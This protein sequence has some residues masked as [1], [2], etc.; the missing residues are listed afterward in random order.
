MYTIGKLVKK[1]NISRSTLLY[2]DKIGL[3][4]PNGRSQSN[5]RLY[6]E[7]DV[8]RLSE[9]MSHREAGIPLSDMNRL[10]EIEKNDVS[11]T[12]SKRLKVIQDEI[13]TLKKQ[14]KMILSVLIQ[15]VKNDTKNYYTKESWTEIL[16]QSGYSDIDLL[17]WHRDFEKDS[18]KEHRS[19]LKALGM[20]PNEIEGLLNKL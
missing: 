8:K 11:E 12:L 6:S 3:L 14:E 1:F 7:N 4:K 18:A 13:R 19:F 20:G 2:Y 9:I 15:E 5:Y 17:Q 10:F 16:I